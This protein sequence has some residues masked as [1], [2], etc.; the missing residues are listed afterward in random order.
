MGSPVEFKC[1]ISGKPVPSS[2]WFKDGNELNSSFEKRTFIETAEDISRLKIESV[3]TSDQGSYT[4]VVN[5]VSGEHKCT[6]TLIVVEGN[7]TA[8]SD[9]SCL[10]ILV[11]YKLLGCS[12]LLHEIF[13]IL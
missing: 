1:K 8:M 3:Q 9:S 11:S 12:T 6:V 10:V 13:V 7:V 2:T 5:N 4:C